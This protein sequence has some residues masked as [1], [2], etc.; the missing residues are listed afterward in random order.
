LKETMK[1]VVLCGLTLL[2]RGYSESF[3][4][5]EDS[6]EAVESLES[7]ELFD[8]I[9]P[10]PEDILNM[11][12]DLDYVDRDD[13]KEE[14]LEGIKEFGQ[15][16]NE[17]VGP[18]YDYNLIGDNDN[19]FL[20]DDSPEELWGLLSDA[21]HEYQDD[22]P[23]DF[24]LE[25]EY[26]INVLQQIDLQINPDYSSDSSE[27]VWIPQKQPRNPIPEYVYETFDGGD[28]FDGLVEEDPLN[29]MLEYDSE[30]SLT[31][32]L[33]QGVP[34]KL[35]PS[36]NDLDN[37]S[38]KAECLKMKIEEIYD[39]QQIFHII[40]LLGISL[41]CVVVLFA[42]ISLVVSIIVRS[43]GNVTSS[44]TNS[45]QGVKQIKLKNNGII[46]SY[47]KIPVEIKNMMPSNVAYKQ[48]YEV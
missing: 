45:T 11:V 17:K 37:L 47:T 36:C 43:Y 2:A 29:S 30:L 48:L 33:D 32:T 38:E 15:M 10:V 12:S 3:S 19:F 42:V 8:D 9:K 7:V 46:R 27:I 39:Q 16:L 14:D 6:N 5:E 23:E 1:L 18:S 35:P 21:Y 13:I 31:P 41:I 22:S 20:S 34:I 44:N 28:I 4:S 25:Q 40:L 24:Y 26:H